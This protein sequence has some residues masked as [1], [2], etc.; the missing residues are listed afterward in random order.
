[1]H[2]VMSMLVRHQRQVHYRQFRP[3][4][5]TAWSRA[6]LDYEMSHG[7]QFW[8]DCSEM[9]TALFHWVGAKDPNGMGFNGWGWSGSIWEHLPHFSN[10]RDAKIGSIVTFGPGGSEHVATVFSPGSDPVLFSHGDEN[11]P[12]LIRL[13][14][15]APYLQSPVTFCAV[16]GL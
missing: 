2:G 14:S 16:A 6:H 4:D 8:A 11:G 7:G 9:T 12:G 15:A 5:I 13:S 10:A 1:M 3:M